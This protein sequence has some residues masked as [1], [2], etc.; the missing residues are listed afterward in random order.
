MVLKVSKRHPLVWKVVKKTSVPNVIQQRILKSPIKV[1][2]TEYFQRQQK[3]GIRWIKR[4]VTNRSITFVKPWGMKSW[5]VNYNGPYLNSKPP[6]VEVVNFIPNTNRSYR[7]TNL[8]LMGRNAVV[9]DV[10]GAKNNGSTA[11]FIVYYGANAASQ[12]KNLQ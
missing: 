6:H 9:W 1:G 11:H 4:K 10:V 3:N 2:K 8:H 5:L 7:L 12:L